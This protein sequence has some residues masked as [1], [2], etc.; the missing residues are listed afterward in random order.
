MEIRVNQEQ[1][2][3]VHKYYS[4][5]VFGVTVLALV[6][7]TFLP[8]PIPQA[9]LLDLPLLVTLYFGLSWRNPSSGLLLGTAIGL[10]Q[11]SLSHSPLGLIG[12]PKTTVGYLASSIGSRLDVE[13][14]ISRLMLTFVFFHLQ[15]VVYTVVKRV[16]LAQ[17]EALINVPLLIA[18][19][20]NAV[21]AVALFP[22]LDRLRKPA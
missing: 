16:L 19:V 6:L 15:H 21:I 20:V 13:H 1:H 10:V 14:P 9:R 18:S 22:L 12:I 2:I 3:E 17:P 5:A 4:G 11:D 8:R 7:Q